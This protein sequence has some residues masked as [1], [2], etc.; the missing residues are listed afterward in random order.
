MRGGTGGGGRGLNPSKVSRNASAER[1]ESKG[2]IAAK[3]AKSASTK[4]RA[5]AMSKMAWE[6][7]IMKVE[8]TLESLN[9][10][11]RGGTAVRVADT[12]DG[13]EKMLWR[14]REEIELRDECARVLQVCAADTLP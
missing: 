11:L 13:V 12:A 10:S 9:Q 5:D 8:R 4:A 7:D 14:M 1:E 2:R 6:R 3:E